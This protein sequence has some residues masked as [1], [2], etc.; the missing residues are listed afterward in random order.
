MA[1]NEFVKVNELYEDYKERPPDKL[2]NRMKDGTWRCWYKAKT[3]PGRP[4]F[5]YHHSEYA[6]WLTHSQSGVLITSARRLKDLKVLLQEPE[7]LEEKLVPS[8]L[9]DAVVRWHRTLF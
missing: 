3:M 1:T 8:K 6:Y 2:A 5:H 9:K 7:F 4:K